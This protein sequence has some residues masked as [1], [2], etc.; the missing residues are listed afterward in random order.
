MEQIYQAR[1][2]LRTHGIRACFFLQFGYP[3][4]DWDDIQSTIRMV[5]ETRPDDIGVSVS[6]PLAGTK[7]YQLVEAQLGAKKNWED[8]DDLAMMFH[9]AY[10]QRI[11]SGAARRPAPGSC[12][13]EPRRDRGEL[14]PAGSAAKPL[15]ERGAHC[16]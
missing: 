12:G 9:G 5:R 7:F 2:N 13:A 1:E 15:D 16:D 11:L 8:S 6:Y 3:G 10:T 4:E 14:A